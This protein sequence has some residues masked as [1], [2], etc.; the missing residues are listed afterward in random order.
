MRSWIAGAVVGAISLMTA[1]AGAA[2][3]TSTNRVN[4]ITD[5]SVFE[6][7]DPR[8]CWAVTTYKES[9]NTRGGRVV[10]V[11][12]GEILLMVFYRPGAEV[13]GQVAFTGGYPFAPGSTVNVNIGGTEFE[14]FTEGEWAWPA[15]PQDDAKIVTAM[16]RG[17][18]AVLTAQSSR[19][20]TTKDTFSLL[21]F[22]AAVEDAEKRCA[23]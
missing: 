17:A 23:Q 6:G 2:Q 5:W 1:G 16:K 10:A 20:T 15:T 12:R 19:G 8:E 14:L 21:G 22:T 13:Q 11:T 18:D 9:V 3:E 7:Q 4:A